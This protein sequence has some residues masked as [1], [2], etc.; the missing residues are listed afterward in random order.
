MASINLLKR[1]SYQDK[2]YS[3][4]FVHEKHSDYY[5]NGQRNVNQGWSALA[6]IKEE[7][8]ELFN[9]TQKF[10]VIYKSYVKYSLI[11]LL[12][13]ILLCFVPVYFLITHGYNTGLVI[14]VCFGVAGLIISSACTAVFGNAL[15]RMNNGNHAESYLVSVNERVKEASSYTKI[16][17]SKWLNNF[18]LITPA[19]YTDRTYQYSLSQVKGFVDSLNDEDLKEFIVKGYE[20]GKTLDL[21]DESETILSS[22][23]GT[24]FLVDEAKKKNAKLN[25]D[26]TE[27]TQLRKKFT[28]RFMKYLSKIN[29]TKT[30]RFNTTKEA[31]QSLLSFLS[32]EK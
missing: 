14:L 1:I 6:S 17:T 9:E 5:N 25:D 28:E 30:N 13:A 29:K 22:Q 4:F 26:L 10:K 2:N 12:S 16:E 32:A 20:H 21:I 23:K 15:S 3:L 19:Y 11:G 31:D 27:L 7:D 8:D 18:S 24:K